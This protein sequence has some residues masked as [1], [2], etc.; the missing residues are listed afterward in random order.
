MPGPTKWESDAPPPATGDLLEPAIDQA[1]AQ[2]A[3]L[4]IRRNFRDGEWPSH[5]KLWRE[6]LQQSR[7]RAQQGTTPRIPKGDLAAPIG[8]RLD[9]RHW[10]FFENWH[11]RYVAE[12]LRMRASDSG[13]PALRAV[14]HANRAGGHPDKTEAMIFLAFDVEN[15][16]DGP[17]ETSEQAT[18]KM[19]SAAP[20]VPRP[21]RFRPCFGTTTRQESREGATE[22]ERRFGTRH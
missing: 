8:I 17:F 22:P 10:T 2:L 21:H 14:R 5:A 6:L 12:E 15:P 9:G 4:A 19:H 1:L 16:A 18:H 20:S 13:I 7:M 11:E 3:G